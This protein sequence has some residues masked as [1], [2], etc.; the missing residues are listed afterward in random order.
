MSMRDTML[1]A[2]AK[3]ASSAASLAGG[4]VTAVLLVLLYLVLLYE[5]AWRE[6]ISG[7]E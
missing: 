3:A 2:V 6:R 7:S 1:T 4:E 5:Q